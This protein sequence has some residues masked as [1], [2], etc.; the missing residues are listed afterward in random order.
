MKPATRKSLLHIIIALLTATAILGVISVL[1]SGF[2]QTGGKVLLSAVGTDA[3]SLLA[4]CCAGPA[5]SAGHRAIQATGI[6]TACGGLVAGLFFLWSGPIVAG[7]AGEGALRAAIVLWA[8]TVASAHTALLYPLH[9]RVKHRRV[10]VAG[11]AL[12]TWAAAELIANFAL[13][14]GLTP[15]GAYV[16]ALTV[17]LILGALGTIVIVL[18]HRFGPPGAGWNGAGSPRTPA[19][20]V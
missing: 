16:K 3:A 15:V 4:L 20:P 8:I 6:L 10:L 18:L 1:W 11:T 2:G 19:P 5:I 7:G 17:L 13:I 9:P 12:C 14:R